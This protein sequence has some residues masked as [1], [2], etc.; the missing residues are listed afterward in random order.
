MHPI[1]RRV[2]V[3]A[4]TAAAAMIVSGCSLLY[5]LGGYP[6][7]PFPYPPGSSPAP[8]AKYAD[9]KATI[10]IDGGA[11]IAL[12]TMTEG[13]TVIPEYGVG[14]TFRNEDGWYLRIMGATK[15]QN[16]FGSTT[17]MTLDRIVDGEHWTTYDPG[18]CAFTITTAD[19]TGLVGK[20]SCKGLRWS[21]AISTGISES[22]QPPYIDQPAFDAE[23]TFEAAPSSTTSS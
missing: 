11:V 5:G 12:P 21:D 15:G 6:P 10:S 1:G 16:T 4:V 8:S 20:A 2:Y 13:G 9:G 7:P 14:A 22:Y 19:A 23:I 17:F 18:R 3:G